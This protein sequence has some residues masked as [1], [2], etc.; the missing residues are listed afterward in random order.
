MTVPS[1]TPRNLSTAAPGATEFPYDFKILEASHLLVQVDGVTKALNVDYTVDGVGNNAGGNVTFLAPLAGGESV[2]RKRNMPFSRSID[3][4]QLGDF[5]SS[6]MNSDQDAPVMMVQQVAES[7]ER[8][9]RLRDDSSAVAALGAPVPG[10]AF[11]WNTSGTE[12]EYFDWTGGWGSPSG[13][14]GIGFLQSG[15]ESV[16]RTAQDKM[17][18]SISVL[19]FMSPAKA[20]D[21]LSNTGLYDHSVEIK[22]ALQAAITQKKRLFLPA[23]T[24]SYITDTKGGARIEPTISNGDVVEI[25]G[26]G[27]GRTI[28]KEVSGGN[29]GVTTDRI[30]NINVPD[31]VTCRQVTVRDLTLDKNGASNGTPPGGAG[32]YDWQQ[33]HA[34]TIYTGTTSGRILNVVVENVET[35]DKVGGG[36]VFAAGF[37]DHAVVRN[38]HGRDFNANVGQRGDLENQAV[39]DF[40]A[41][42]DCTGLYVQSEPNVTTASGKTPTT[43]FRNCIYDT[44]E[45]EGFTADVAAQRTVIE[46]CI[47]SSKLL[48]RDMRVTIRGGRYQVDSPSYWRRMAPG[49]AMFGGTI[50]NKYDGGANSISPFYP[51]YTATLGGTEMLFNGVKFEPG[52]GASG[53]TTGNCIAN[54]TPCTNAQVFKLKFVDCEFSPLYERTIDAYRAGTYEFI[55]CKFGGWATTTGALR[56]GSD[57]TNLGNV[58]IDSCD[59]SAVT[60]TYKVYRQD[61]GTNWTLRWRGTHRYSE[62]TGSYSGA[63]NLV[64]NE[65]FDG[66]FVSRSVPTGGGVIGMRVRVTNAA[67]GTASEYIATTN[68]ASASTWRMVAQNG[69]KKDTTANRPTPAAADIGLAYLDTTLDADGK[70]IWWNGTAWV[71]ATGAV[72]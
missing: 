35:L 37:I 40:L 20:A 52:A 62:Y 46:N 44:I 27:M 10:Y 18:E 12:V 21:A 43:V 13:S 34:L 67:Y 68:S 11:R 66:V 61:G 63:T 33:S 39:I 32:A 53:T 54:V 2:L 48:I 15:D 64:A 36:I 7:I 28:I 55:R 22:K 19:D 31:G 26:E 57:T 59:F 56:V 16:G 4:Q 6:T 71:D 51:Q 65:N 41:V 5:G 47:A 38:C 70:P 58:T 42:E 8:A 17:R 30:I 25:Y 49:S 69:I 50:V 45:L 3:Y 1:Q 23:G 29:I 14:S 24:Y 72:V 60:A 9:L